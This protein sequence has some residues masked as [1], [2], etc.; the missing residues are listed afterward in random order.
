MIVR[1]APVSTLPGRSAST[2]DPSGWA[3]WT[4]TNGAGGD[5]FGVP[6]D[7][8]RHDS[9][10]ADDPRRRGVRDRF[11]LV[12]HLAGED[13][14][15]R[16][17]AAWARVRASSGRCPRPRRPR[18]G[19]PRTSPRGS[20]SSPAACRSKAS[21]SAASF[22]SV[23]REGKTRG[24][25]SGDRTTSNTW[26]SSPGRR[27]VISNSASPTGTSGGRVSVT[28]RLS[29]TVAL[30]LDGRHRLTP[31]SVR[32]PF[33]PPPDG[34][35]AATGGFSRLR[36][37]TSFALSNSGCQV[38]SGSPVDHAVADLLQ[39]VPGHVRALVA[40]AGDPR[41]RQVR[42][43]RVPRSPA[44]TSC[45]ARSPRGSRSA[46]RATPTYLIIASV[47]PT[48]S[49]CSRMFRGHSGWAIA[50]RLRELLL[51]LQQVVDAE[52]LVDHARPVP[53]DHLP[54]G[55][56]L[57]VPAQVLVRDEQDLVVRRHLADDLLGVAGRDHP[58]G[59]GLHR[60]RA[61]DVR[62]RLELPAVLAEHLLVAGELVR[63]AAVDEAAP[64]LQVRAAAPSSPG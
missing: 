53:Q 20:S 49:A 8:N 31:S 35:L 17:G 28:C 47:P 52:D 21:C 19:P 11:G 27:T 34:R 41:H 40:R 63:R 14:V 7:G 15:R 44:A 12:R 61:V 37:S 54:P 32:L 36:A 24:P 1:S 4:R 6:V 64:G 59:Q 2:A 33:S 18:R 3:R 22:G 48:K 55:H 25:S 39:R 13:R 57:Q 45:S 16:G 23:G 46:P 29:G 26:A 51:H 5:S 62:H 38:I 43:L 10:S 60:G 50:C 58:V 9:P 42:V 30:S 56:L